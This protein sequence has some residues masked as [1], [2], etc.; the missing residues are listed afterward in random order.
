MIPCGE[1]LGV[2]IPCVPEIMKKHDILGLRVVRWC[3]QW[4]EPGQSYVALEDYEPL[5]ITTTS[6]H[7]S[8]TIR[9]WWQNEGAGKDFLRDF[10]K[11]EGID[12]NV[13][14]EK[15][16]AFVLGTIARAKSAFCIH[17]IQDLLHLSPAYYDENPDAERVNVPG[18]VTDFNWTYRIPKTVAQLSKD[19]ALINEIKNIVEAHS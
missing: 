8:S 3:R 1:D 10:D 4:E 16:A 15:T 6:V 19:K 11:A 2:N 12:A 13:F 7:D 14:D 5:S 17:P 9:G 18:S